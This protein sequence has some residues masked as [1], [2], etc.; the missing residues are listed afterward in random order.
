MSWLDGMAHRLRTLL[1]P[2]RY[3]AELDEEFQHHLDLDTMHDGDPRRAVRRFGNRLYH[4]EETRAMTWL[5]RFD[6][7]RQDLRTAWRGVARTPSLAVLVVITLA[8]GVGANAT[9]FTLLDTLYFRPPSGVADPGSLRRYWVEQHFA[10]GTSF[11]R[12]WAIYP[13]Q[14][15]L[16][17][18]TDNADQVALYHGPVTHRLGRGFGGPQITVLYTSANYF[19]VLGVQLALGRFYT[20][21]EDSLGRGAP[22][23]VVSHAFWTNH[24][25]GDPN[26]IGRAITL[27]ANDVTVVGV[28]DSSFRGWTSNRLMSGCRSPRRLGGRSGG[29]VPP[30]GLCSAPSSAGDCPRPLWKNGPPR[31]CAP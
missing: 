29:R 4:R 27:G 10:T 15:I 1:R 30:V 26:A 20:R 31:Y 2:G 11:I 3:A 14:H 6:V 13:T 19:P 24:L 7:L 28:L 22:V 25:G 18:A 21:D 9:T 17:Q 5:H 23:A 12:P 16:V 8:L